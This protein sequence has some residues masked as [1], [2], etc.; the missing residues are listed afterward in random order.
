MPPE[1]PGVP[2]EIDEHLLLCY[3]KGAND[4]RHSGWRAPSWLMALEDRSAQA[5]Q[6]RPDVYPRAAEPEPES[7]PVGWPCL[8]CT[9]VNAYEHS[10]CHVC[11]TPRQPPTDGSAVQTSSGPQQDEA[12]LYVVL[13]ASGGAALGMHTASWAEMRQRLALGQHGLCGSGARIKRVQS[14][15]AAEECWLAAGMSRPMPVVGDAPGGDRP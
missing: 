7:Q 10:T 6:A 14:R 4:R 11:E 8:A 15:G 5:Y 9:L 1:S 2:E 3:V 13:R 12:R